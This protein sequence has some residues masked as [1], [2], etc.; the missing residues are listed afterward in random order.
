MFDAIQKGKQHEATPLFPGTPYAIAKFFTHW[1]TVNDQENNGLNT[2]NDAL[3]NNVSP[4]RGIEFAACKVIGGVARVKT[5]LAQALRPRNFVA[6][7]DWEH[8]R[9]YVHIV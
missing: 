3:C 4:L 6:K 7:R 8:T 2:S 1:L 9:D 5:W